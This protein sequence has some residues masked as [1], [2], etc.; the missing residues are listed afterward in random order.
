MVS[1]FAVTKEQVMNQHKLGINLRTASAWHGDGRKRPGV[2]RVD[3][4]RI[5]VWL[6]EGLS[7]AR[8]R[9]GAWLA[10][11]LL[12]ADLATA[13]ELCTSLQIAVTLLVP[14]LAG[15]TMLMQEYR[16]IAS[17]STVRE[18]LDSVVRQRDALFA[19]ALWVAAM[20]CIGSLLSRAVM[21]V[22]PAPWTSAFALAV[23]DLALAVAIAAVWF[24]PALI[25]LHRCSSLEA[26]ATSLR[27]VLRNWPVAL[28]YALLIVVDVL[29]AP[30]T[31]MIVRGL[32]V[33]PLISALIVLSMHASYRDIIYRERDCG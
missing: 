21:L 3:V 1:V 27:A 31:P 9:P 17:R 5:R 11:I 20:V 19:V 33:T 22:N 32:V 29:T 16:R 25:V 4:S 30:F 26:M 23:N 8:E 13:L 2:R 18:T 10:T 7:A 6:A 28:C 15:A 24:A 14:V 12:S